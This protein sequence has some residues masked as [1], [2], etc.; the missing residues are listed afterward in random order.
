MSGH[1]KW[2][3]IKH[4]KAAN[5]ATRG[6][7]F[8]KHAKLITVAVREG[9][10]I[11]DPDKNPSLRLAIDN[12]K[13]DNTPNTNIERAIR[14]GTGE[15]KDD[16]QLYEVTYEAIGPGGTALMITTLTDNK[17]RTFPNIRTAVEKKGGTMGAAGSAA[18]MFEKKGVISAK[19]LIGDEAEMAIIES[20]A[21]NYEDNNDGTFGI[22]TDM[23]NLHEVC[24]SLRSSGFEIEKAEISFV[25]KDDKKIEDLE[26]ARKII[27]LM[28][29]LDEDEDVTDI[30][31]N[32]DIS[33]EIM[34]QL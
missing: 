19:G 24:A 20:G 1:S 10:G 27:N 8:T 2:H 18:W 22:Y 30:S 34:E 33:N 3:S 16:T 29:T 13:K 32:F 4:K 7:I 21:D 14:K 6:K 17:N 9:G 25:A 11:G 31:G 26:T 12:A 23:K 28:D 15:D 5:D